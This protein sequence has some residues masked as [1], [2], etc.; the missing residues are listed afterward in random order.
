MVSDLMQGSLGS[1]PKYLTYAGNGSLFFAA[2]DGVHGR[3]L[4]FVAS[5]GVVRIVHD[6]CNGVC[7]SN[8]AN[9]AVFDDKIFYQAS[10]S[11]FGAELYYVVLAGGLPVGAPVLVKDIHVGSASSHPSFLTVFAPADSSNEDDDRARVHFFANSF[12]GVGGV[13]LWRT[14]GN[15][16]R[17]VIDNTAK[18]GEVDEKS[19]SL[20]HPQMMASWK[21]ALYFSMNAFDR[22]GESATLPRGFL[23]SVEHF[24]PLNHAIVLKDAE[25]DDVSVHLSCEKCLIELDYALRVNATFLEGAGSP[26]GRI[27]FR[28]PIS[29]ANAILAKLWVQ[30]AKDA[31][32]H[33]RIVIA[34]NDSHHV[35]TEDIPLYLNP[36]ND[37]PVISSPETFIVSPG[38][39]VITGISVS[40]ADIGELAMLQNNGDVIGGYLTVTV[41]T[42][43]GS[44][45][46]HSLRGLGLH[47]GNAGVR[48]TQIAFTASLEA[49]N[50][51]LSRLYLDCSGSQDEDED[52]DDRELS[53]CAGGGIITIDVNDNGFYGDDATSLS[54][55]KGIKIIFEH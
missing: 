53:D 18:D 25:N 39:S 5:D 14:D 17:R 7:S 55:S 49:T 48:E 33:D 38:E 54:D 15:D 27:S 8:P 50:F 1:M 19:L 10:E 32:G 45:T 4:F 40:D 16:T 47:E 11:N 37:P 26:S 36:K 29:A 3:E 52:E 20:Q 34:V 35:V 13:E 28:A 23:S 22:S 21:H 51:A 24:G 43:V 41:S 6:L 30:G 12:S 42:T 2:N 31:N 44:L 46:L 9:L